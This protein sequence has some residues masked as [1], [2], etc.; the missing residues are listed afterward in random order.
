[1]RKFC[2][3][4]TPIIIN[5]IN[6]TN[7]NKTKQNLLYNSFSE[8]DSDLVCSHSYLPVSVKYLRREDKDSQQQ[9]KALQHPEASFTHPKYNYVH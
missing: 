9:S 7:T 5:L 4:H 2:L 8:Y 3:Y 1:M 6:E